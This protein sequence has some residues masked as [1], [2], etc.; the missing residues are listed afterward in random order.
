MHENLTSWIMRSHTEAK[1]IKPSRRSPLNPPPCVA[2]WPITPSPESIEVHL[3][4]N[5]SKLITPSSN[6]QPSIMPNYHAILFSPGGNWRNWRNGRPPH[7]P[8]NRNMMGMKYEVWRGQEESW[9]LSDSRK[10]A[11][12]LSVGRK[13]GQGAER[14]YRKWSDQSAV[15]TLA[16]DFLTEIIFFIISKFLLSWC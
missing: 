2:K 4:I 5:A 16:S 8:V 1:P 13:T 3:Y 7:H 14:R 15:F 12:A 6:G 11:S 10:M 9:V